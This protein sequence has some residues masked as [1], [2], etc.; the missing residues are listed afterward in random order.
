LFFQWFFQWFSSFS[1]HKTPKCFTAAPSA[2]QF[3]HVPS[4]AL[5]AQIIIA[6]SNGRAAAH[7]KKMSTLV[8]WAIAPGTWI[9]VVGADW[10]M[11]IQ[12][13]GIFFGIT[14]YSIVIYV[15]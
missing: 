9:P 14:N 2:L 15:I 3:L 10:N 5:L 11:G 7:A 1:T 13:M 6:F 8:Q 12:N 4:E